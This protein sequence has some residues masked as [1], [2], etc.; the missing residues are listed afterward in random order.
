MFGFRESFG[1]VECGAC[2]CLQIEDP[3]QDPARYYPERYYSFHAPVESG[4]KL[5]LKRFRA[6]QA[7]GRPNV[8]GWILSARFGPPPYA[9]WA[10]TAG[11]GIHA[12]VL[13]VGCGSG[14]LLRSMR[15]GGFDDLTGVDP[16]VA[17]DINHPDGVR[18][19]RRTHSEHEERYDLILFNHTFEPLPHPR[20]A[21]VDARRLLAHD[22]TVLIRIP[23]AGSLAWRRY[24]VDWVQLDAPRHAYLHTVASLRFLASKT[25]FDVVHVEWDSDAFQFWGS[26]QY[27]RDIPLEDPRSYAKDPRGSIFTKAQIRAFEEEARRLNDRGEGDAACFYLR[28]AREESTAS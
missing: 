2:G 23:V 5:L 18:V 20:G 16:Y 24:G 14:Q 21:L 22:G 15:L 19:L 10:R 9:V 3:P 11:I 17:R 4:L 28:G 26:E 1:Y 8:L 6:A 13:D 12:A 25:G 27:V 7:M